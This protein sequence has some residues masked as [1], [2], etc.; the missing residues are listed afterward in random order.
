MA[1]RA[2]PRDPQTEDFQRRAFSLLQQ[3]Y[4]SAEGSPDRRLLA[5]RIADAAGV[6]R[7]EALRL[8]EFLAEEGHLLLD[9]AGPVVG[10]TPPGKAYI[11]QLAWR[12]RSV[13]A[14]REA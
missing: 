2:Q 8:M 3:I 11:E 12:R 9:P 5:S 10:L 4:T 1:T 6:D 13:R 7:G 14:R